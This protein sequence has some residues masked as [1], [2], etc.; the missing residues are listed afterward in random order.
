MTTRR[1]LTHWAIHAFSMVLSCTLLS[2]LP[3]WV[4]RAGMPLGTSHFRT[5][6]VKNGLADNFVRH[7]STDSYGFVWFA[8]INGV[9]RFDGYRFVNYQPVEVGAQNDNVAWVCETADRTLW[10][11]CG[12]EGFTYDRQHNTWS[13]DGLERL[14]QLGIKGAP[15]LLYVDDHHNLWVATERELYLYD[16]TQSRLHRIEYFNPSPIVHIVSRNGKTLVVTKKCSVYEVALDKHQLLLV[17][18][19]PELTFTRDS[20]VFLD[21]KMTLWAYNSHAPASAVWCLPQ[22]QQL[23]RQAMP[24]KQMGNPLVNTITEDND[25]QLWVGTEDDGIHVLT[26]LADDGLTLNPVARM[27]AFE[28]RNSHITSIFLDNNNTIWVGSA[29][30]GVVF[31]DRN[32]PHF[33]FVPTG[34]S[35]DVTSLLEDNEGNLWIGFDGGGLMRKTPTGNVTMFS[36]PPYSSTYEGTTGGLVT[37]LAQQKDGSVLVGTYG[38]GIARFDG[39]RLVPMWRDVT[40]IKYVKAITPDLHGNLWVATVDRGVVRIDADGNTVNFTTENSSLLSDGVLCLACDSLHNIIYIGTSQGVSAYDCNRDNFVDIKAIDGLKGMYIYSLIVCHQGKLW[41]GS[42]DGIWI[43]SPLNN[44][45]THL[46]TEQGLSHPVVRALA[47]AVYPGGA[48]VW[49]TTDNGLTCISVKKTDDNQCEYKCNPFFDTDGLQGIIFSNNAALTAKDGSALLGCFTGYVSIQPENMMIHTPRLQVRFTDF[50]INGQSSTNHSLANLTIRHNERPT[51]FVSAMLPALDR[52]IKYLYRFKGEKEWERAPDNHLYF[53]SLMPG[54]HIL[55]VKA[56]LPGVAESE[57]AELTIKVQPPLWLSW[58]A[59]LFYLLL[60]ATAVGLIFRSVRL[61]QKRQLAIRQLEMNLE[62]YE[63][64]EEKIRF[65]TNISHDLKTPLTL[66]VAPLEKIRSFSLPASIRTEVE[67]AWRNARQLYDLVLQLLDFRRLDEGREK[68][69][70]KHG[71]VLNFVR[72]TVQGFSYLATRKQIKLML[73]LPT[74]SIEAAFD[75]NKLRRIISNL[76]SNA[77]KYNTEN[78]AVTVSLAIRPLDHSTSNHLQDNDSEPSPLSNSSELLL[79]IADTGIGVND[80]RHIFDRFVQETHGQEQEGSGLG[81]HIVKQYVD[82]M[83]GSI[84]VADNK[85]QG[86]IFTVKLPLSETINV[87]DEELPT[88]KADTIY[89]EVNAVDGTYEKPIILVVDDNIDARQFLQRSLD[90]EYQVLVAENGREALRL[91]AKTDRVSIIVSDVMMPVMD[92]IE[93][94]RRIKNNINY[95]HIPVILLTAK[96]GEEN[97][98]AGLEEGVADYITKPFSLAVLKLRIRKIMEWSQNVHKSIATG[99]EIKPSEITV[100][101]LDEELISNVIARIEANISNADYSVAQLSSDVGM[102]RGHLYK[103]LMAITGKP[104]LEMMRIIKLKRGK[105]LLQQGRSNISEVADK[106]GLSPKQ[107]AHYFKLVYGETPS[108][109]LKKQK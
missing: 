25:G 99:I 36:V 39:H 35:E 55:Q 13:K 82:M 26:R 48:Y 108:D 76:L 102:T 69:N 15:S 77:F 93:L 11:S 68:L 46:S 44:G 37:A 62:K 41:I 22:G 87:D 103:K 23:W 20:R 19:P 88:T 14:S 89:E 8:T 31:S 18:Q 80:K 34:N 92:G 97:I 83:G 45:V 91:L 1:S 58:P 71:D 57:I 74:S 75:E 84:S 50:R 70:L 49:A 85:P 3:I 59:L 4:A 64:E 104:P 54:T 32:I 106:V 105:S 61:R 43:Y 51:I 27:N 90:D 107:F 56:E 2:L 60:L 73:Q 17:A 53:A 63:M 109:Y 72:Q 95:S 94:F 38:S 65:F 101:S 52:K 42:R 33:V 40:S 21:S 29:K 100:S 66:V 78:G 86:T 98:V 9:S 67:V 6:N 47:K 96:S 79:S 24:V 30:L 28:S 7:I 10:M 5:L 12:G 16:F 81:L